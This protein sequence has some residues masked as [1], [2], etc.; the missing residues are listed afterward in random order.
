[1]SHLKN[2]SNLSLKAAKHLESNT[3]YYNSTVHCAYY[4]CLQ[5]TKYILEKEYQLQGELQ[6]NQ[7]RGSHDYMLKRMRGIIK[8]N[9][10]KRFNAID[11]YENCTELKTLRVNADYN[12][13]E[14]LETNAQEAIKFADEVIR[15]LTNNFSI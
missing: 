5:M 12:N 3:N 14:I 6:A 2:K 9:K 1:M 13:I 15:I 8:D 10:G 11:Y 7:G 4:S